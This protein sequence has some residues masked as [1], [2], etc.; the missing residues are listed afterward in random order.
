ML[1]HLVNIESLTKAEIENIIDDAISFKNGHDKSVFNNKTVCIMFFENSTRTKIS[2]EMAAKNLG[3]K[4][5]N[6]D[7][8]TSS[9]NKGESLKETMENLYFIGVNG[10][11]IR[12]SDD[13][14]VK[15][16]VENVSYPI[17]LLNAGT[18]K[19]SHTTQALLDYFTM[20]EKLG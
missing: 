6:F 12:T 5:I 10:V 9:I 3:M 20:K 11:I 17:K 1:N 19:S 18:G 16:L 14:L 2:F 13:N 7:T 8:Q 4:V 15:N